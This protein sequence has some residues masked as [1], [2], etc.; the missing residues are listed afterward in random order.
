MTISLG[1]ESPR[2]SCSLP[3]AADLT[4]QVASS[5]LPKGLPLLDLAPGG[6]YLAADITACAGGLLHHLFTLTTFFLTPRQNPK[7]LGEAGRGLRFIS[8]ALSVRLPR[9]GG[10]PAPCPVECGLS[11]MALSHRG[12]PTSLGT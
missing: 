7:D 8:V 9:P 3:E 2:V 12:H 10:Y 5:H 6:G 1:R 4:I 11:S